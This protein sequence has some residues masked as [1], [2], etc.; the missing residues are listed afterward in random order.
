MGLNKVYIMVRESI[1]MM[2]PFPSLAQAFSLLIQE[3]K[4]R[5][6]KPNNQLM[7]EFASLNVN[8]L[9]RTSFKTNYNP[10]NYC[11]P[12]NRSRPICE[13]FKKPGHT[14]EK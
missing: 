4:Q 13:Y 3:E 1:L 6:I 8:T 7:F 9:R 11:T 12:N 14:K 2:K 5:E 10:G